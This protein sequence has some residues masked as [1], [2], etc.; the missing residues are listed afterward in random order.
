MHYRAARSWEFHA[1]VRTSRRH[2]CR[3]ERDLAPFS[4]QAAVPEYFALWLEQRHPRLNR[5]IRP[6][7][8]Y[9]LRE[10]A[11]M[12]LYLLTLEA[13]RSRDTFPVRNHLFGRCCLILRVRME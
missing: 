12:L 1:D 6:K 9:S 8:S 11:S 10:E 4:R 5:G 7:F 2:P 13:K 3:G